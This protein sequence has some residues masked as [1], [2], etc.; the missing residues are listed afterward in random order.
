MLTLCKGFCD[1]VH[2]P[3]SRVDQA[4]P[5]FFMEAVVEQGVLF[6]VI[7]ERAG[8][9]SALRELMDAIERHGPLLPRAAVPLVMDLS[10]QRIHVLINE[11]RLATV[12]VRGREYVPIAAL[13]LFMAE[14][15]KAGR[16][17]EELSL[18]DSYRKH[19]L[20]KSEK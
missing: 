6:P 19:L 18:S 8:K 10:R 14:E 12:F 16:P 1:S 15:R 5:T 3:W 11:G 9:R 20:K 7:E 4:A 13:E 17:V 2:A